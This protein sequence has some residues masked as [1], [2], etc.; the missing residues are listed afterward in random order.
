[1]NNTKR[2]ATCAVLVAL[3]TALAIVSLVIP[4]QLPFGGSVT[5]ASMLPIAVAAYMY[6]TKWG[7]GTA[8]VFSVIQML[9]GAQTVSAFFMPG[10]GQIVWYKA[11]IVCVLDYVLA[12]TVIGFSG[13][14][15]KTIKNPAASLFAGSAVAVTIRYACHIVSGAIFFGTWAEGF[16]AEWGP[17]A[18]TAFGSWVINNISGSSLVWFYSVVYNGLYMIPEIIITSVAGFA[19]AGILKK[20]IV[21]SK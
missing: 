4:L 5:F 3:A 13:M 21:V 7:L 20:Y 10:D 1:M 17:F 12:Y 2:L 9:L 11:I 16:F 14:F 6:G 8:F 19:V 18:G 15:S